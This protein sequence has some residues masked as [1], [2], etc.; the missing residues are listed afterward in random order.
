MWNIELWRDRQVRILICL[1]A[2]EPRKR[3][4]TRILGH[5]LANLLDGSENM[6]VWADTPCWIP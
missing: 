4:R 3:D 6:D 2:S 1:M 5:D